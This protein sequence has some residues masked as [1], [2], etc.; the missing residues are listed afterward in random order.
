MLAA[1]PSEGSSNVA[2]HSGVQIIR[3]AH[4]DGDNYRPRAPWHYQRFANLSIESGS[5]ERF[6]I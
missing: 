6:T 5:S 1:C 4:P 2:K 3:I